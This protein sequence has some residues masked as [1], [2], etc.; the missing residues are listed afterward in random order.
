MKHKLINIF[1][2]LISVVCNSQTTETSRIYKLERRE[3]VSKIIGESKQNIY[4]L[5]KRNNVLSKNAYSVEVFDK[6]LKS[7]KKVIVVLPQTS[8]ETTIKEVLVIQDE[9]FVF[10]TLLDKSSKTKSAY[11]LK[12]YSDTEPIKISESS[13][14]RY[15]NQPI[16]N[17]EVDS[18]NLLIVTTPAYNKVQ[19]QQFKVNVVDL[20]LN[21]VLDETI[22]LPYPSKDF[23]LDKIQYAYND[24]FILGN[25]TSEKDYLNPKSFY[26]IRHQSASKS[27]KEIEL[28]L[29]SK[30]ITSATF[31]IA[32]DSSLYI[33]GFYSNDQ[34]F[35]VAGTFYLKVDLRDNSILKQSLKPFSKELLSK[36]LP[37]R[38]VKKGKELSAFYFRNFVLKNDGSVVFVAEQY[39]KTTSAYTDMRTGITDYSTNYYYNDIILINVNPLGEI[40]WAKH[41]PKKQSSINDYGQFSSFALA[42]NGN[43][44]FIIFNDHPKNILSINRDERLRFLSN[45]YRS[46][47]VIAK[48]SSNGDITYN[49]LPR[50]SSLVLKPKQNVFSEKQKSLLMISEK[51]KNYS[52]TRINL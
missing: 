37:P 47:P 46:M 16:F 25:N 6:Q 34:K 11:I 33:G 8:L 35:S 44:V 20:N 1:F 51:G 7:T 45:P 9:L 40:S 48:V 22:Q 50:Q 43:D 29:P 12:L 32:K 18:L 30:W 3:S 10:Y 5:K 31:E 52:L 41:I 19:N 36:L 26:L 21:P 39:Y 28:T 38:K 13:F 2:I 15:N 14:E 4:I 24:A 23:S 42:S 27:I 17:I 49:K